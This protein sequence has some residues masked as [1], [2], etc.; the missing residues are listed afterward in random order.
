[1]EP[2]A[3]PRCGSPAAALAAALLGFF[4]I[5]LDSLVVNVALPTIRHDL[6]GGIAG[7]SS[8]YGVVGR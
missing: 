7:L 2:A 5:T 6:G 1:V 8:P 3:S 4:V